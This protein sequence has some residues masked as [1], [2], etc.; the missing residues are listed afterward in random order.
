MKKLVPY[1][2]LIGLAFGCDRPAKETANE[3]LT[4]E[5]AP[6]PADKV[7]QKEGSTW[8]TYEGTLPCAD[9]SGI[10]MTLR[11]ENRAEKNARE[12]KLSQ[13]Y[14]GTTDGDRTFESS[15]VYEVTYG[16][17]GN[18]GAMIITLLDDQENPVKHFLQEKD[19]DEL[20]MLDINKKKIISD[21]NYSLTI[22]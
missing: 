9:C 7:L 12:Y 2:F 3:E 14:L 5:S 8:F 10:K 13:A 19:S 15:G 21:L 1:V 4:T 6:E 20:I 22:K 17:E 16:M 11:L 18:P